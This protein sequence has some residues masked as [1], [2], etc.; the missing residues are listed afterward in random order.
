MSESHNLGK[1]GEDA[2]AEYLKKSGYRILKR[3]WKAGKHEIDIISENRD[4]IVFVEVKTRSEDFQEDPRSAINREKQRSVI[5]AAD[6]YIRWNKID[7]ESR[8]DVIIV[9]MK[10]DLPQIDHIEDAFYPTLR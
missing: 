6:N 8:F 2:A 1:K 10:D 9:I 5:L 4:F 3:N 7:K